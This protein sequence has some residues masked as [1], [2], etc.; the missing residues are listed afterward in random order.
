[1]LELPQFIFARDLPGSA[2]LL[3]S[4]FCRNNSAF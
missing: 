3:H 2:A 4:S 1:M